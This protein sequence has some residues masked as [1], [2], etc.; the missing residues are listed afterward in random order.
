[1]CQHFPLRSVVL[2]SALLVV[3]CGAGD[4]TQPPNQLLPPNP[5]L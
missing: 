1:M 3:A 5:A 4:L 2:L